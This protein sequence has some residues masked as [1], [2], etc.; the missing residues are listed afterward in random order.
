MS[1]VET[2]AVPSQTP[3]PTPSGADAGGPKARAAVRA[4]VVGNYV[5]QFNIFLPVVAL[6]PAL[7]TVAGPH[8][9]VTAG[10]LVIVATLLGRPVGSMVFGQIA[11]RIGRTRTTK[12]AI[13]GTAACS[14]AIAAVPAH[15]VIGAWAITVII[16]LRFIGGAF[17]AGEYTSAIP[18]AMEWS[19]PRRRGLFSGLIMSM[20]PLAQASIAFATVGLIAALGM[21][22]YAAW[23]W[24]IVFVIGGTASLALLAYYSANVVDAPD[25]VAARSTRPARKF[26]LARELR[27]VL[28]G[29]HAGAFWQMFGLMTGLWLMTNMVVI[30][31]TGRLAKD[32][33]LTGDR[34]ATV[35]G[36]AALCQAVVMACTGHLSS[37]LGRRRFFVMWG[38]MAAAAGPAL[39][40]ATMTT[41]ALAPALGVGL[42]QILTVCGYGPVG[43]YLC[44]R[45]PAG[46]RS[47]GYG[48][49][50]S[51]SIIAPA[52]WPFWMPHLEGVLGHDG[53]VLVV[54][55]VGGLLVAGWGSLGPRLAPADLD[56]PVEVVAHRPSADD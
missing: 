41:G 30:N 15:S 39:W 7:A 56:R 29:P 53:A 54:L 24:R 49:A 8:A 43:A 52:L 36:V 26:S 35:M 6:A 14:L 42:L 50:Y 17:L 2:L 9:A 37:L 4:G 51:L 45:F 21:A 34:V 33:G 46:V 1:I 13:A 44:E 3:D 19:R 55:A 20:A 40:Y 5:D 32:L 31:L 23:G 28:G 48:T 10:A 12:I 16:A 25:T 11:D 18:L 47:T 22:D 27:T 38:L